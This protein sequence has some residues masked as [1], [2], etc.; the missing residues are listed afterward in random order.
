MASPQLENGYT[1]L[2]NELLEKILEYP[3][4][5]YELKIILK[6]IRDT[7][8]WKAKKRQVSFGKIAE[9][10]GIDRRNVVNACSTLIA[11]NILFK[12]KLKNNKNLWGINKNYEEWLAP[13]RSLFQEYSFRQLVV[14]KQLRWK[15]I[16]IKNKFPPLTEI[17]EQEINKLLKV[18]GEE[19]FIEALKISVKQNN[20]KLAYIEGILKR[21]ESGNTGDVT[22]K[23]QISD[24]RWMTDEELAA[25]EMKGEIYYDR[26]TNKWICVGDRK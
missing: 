25:A 13:D 19:K 22:N 1:Q 7:Y 16:W 26:E 2:S 17:L 23:T 8:G 9:K 20:K 14:E 6:I 18:Y 15:N 5:A 10:T 24:G 21:Q 11:R 12:Q 4:K 3:F